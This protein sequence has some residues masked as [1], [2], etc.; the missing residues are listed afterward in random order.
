M[1][2]RRFY[3]SAVAGARRSAPAALRNRQF[4]ADVLAD[5]LPPE[6]LVLEVAS[7]TGEH[8]VHFAERFPQLEWQ[9]SDT[10]EDALRS[11]AAWRAEAARPNVRQP[12][13]ID[14]KTSDWPIG[15]ADALLSI[16]MVHIS[17]WEASQA[18]LAGAKRILSA[19]APLILYGPWL[20]DDIETAPSNL[21]FDDQLK[22]VDPSWGLRNVQTF[23]DE[24]LGYGMRL[25]ETRGMPANNLMLRFVAE[26]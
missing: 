10:N 19:G 21:A 4:I 1:T 12:L 25:A 2:E 18:L 13:V 8:V 6:G 3:E 7:G 15:R 23:A 16:N 17:P 11:I 26:S 5:W 24:A 9:A 20:S 14:V 22:S